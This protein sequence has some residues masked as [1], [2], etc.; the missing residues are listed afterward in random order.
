[1]KGIAQISF[2]ESSVESNIEHVF[3]NP[4]LMGGG[5][6]IFDLNNDG[7][8]DLYFT[9]G[10]YEDK[11]YKNLGNG[12]FEEIGSQTAI[13]DTRVVKT[14]SVTTGD[15][16]NDGYRDIFVTSERDEPSILFYNNGN[17]TFTNISLEAG[18][19]ETGWGMGALF[20][21][22]NNDGYLDIYV[23][24][25]IQQF[26]SILDEETKEVVGFDHDCRENYVY[27]NNGDLTF[28]EVGDSLNANSKGCGLAITTTD[29]NNDQIPDAYIANDFGQ[30]IIPN[31]AFVYDTLSNR[32]SEMS[33]EYGLN[34]QM[35][36]MGIATGD[37]D[38]DGQMDYYVSDIGSNVLAHNN[39]NSTFTDRAEL[40]GVLCDTVNSLNS[41]SWGTAFIDVDNNGWEDL[42]VANGYIPSAKFIETSQIDPDK[43]F[44]NQKDGSFSDISGIAG[45]DYSGISRGMAYG[46]LNRD[47]LLDVVIN[48]AH[49]VKFNS[50]NVKIYLNQSSGLD[51]NWLGVKLT[52]TQANMDGIGS[53]VKL[54]LGNDLQIRESTTGGSHASQ[55][56]SIIH[57]GIEKEESIDSI[58]VI[59]P[60]GKTQKFLNIQDINQIINITEDEQQYEVLGCTDLNSINYNPEADIDYGCMYEDQVTGLETEFIRNIDFYPNPAQDILYI[61]SADKFEYQ[62]HIINNTGQVLIEMTLLPGPGMVNEV[63]ISE[64]TPGMYHLKLQRNDQNILYSKIIIE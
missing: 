14:M 62:A 22:I 5:V 45:I 20:V 8:E 35:Y 54:Y 63:N 9:G 61:K 55:H 15:I 19:T 11:L 44:I 18:I 6:S 10:A 2:E 58:V 57:F 48:V 60:G 47:G 7:L 16:D 33:E 38:H 53:T 4:E 46:D 39:G 43:L 25:Y 51:N 32:Y 50:E 64:L 59:W 40:A 42:F 56:S 37:Y 24:N 3:V 31:Q 17:E 12:T 29:L 36:G 21:D 30:W 26:N 23:I 1:M 28:T 13:Y 27:L 41:T 34:F 49:R 52:G